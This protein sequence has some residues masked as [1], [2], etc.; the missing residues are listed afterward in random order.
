[1]IGFLLYLLKN[2]RLKTPVTNFESK[3]DRV[4][5][6]ITTLE[7][8]PGKKNQYQKL[9]D[10]LMKV[11]VLNTLISNAA[12]IKS[13]RKKV[14][15][16]F[17]VSSQKLVYVRILKSASTSMLSELLPLIDKNLENIRLTNEQ[18]DVLATQYVRRKLLVDEDSYNYFAVIRNPFSRLVSVYLDLFDSTAPDF[19]YS[20]FLFGILNKNMSFEEF[21]RALAKIPDSLKGPHFAPQSYIVSNTGLESKI[22]C[23][24]LEKDEE[25]LKT[26]LKPYG[27]AIPHL[28]RQEKSY[29][30][31]IFYTRELADLAYT[32]YKEDVQKFGYQQDYQ[33]LI[34]FTGNK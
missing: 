10:S 28:N 15:Q 5:G 32:I 29:D 3:A 27:I 9:R 16:F 7:P 6:S 25:A 26:F 12:Y 2:G 17:V 20:E 8:R 13:G 31:R 24:R 18:I 33:G 34:E 11:P 23:F 1:M 14:N 30:Y 19:A 4:I 21:V 22:N